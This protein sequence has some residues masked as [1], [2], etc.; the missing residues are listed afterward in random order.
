[1][2]GCMRA[3][4]QS[5]NDDGGDNEDIKQAQRVPPSAFRSRTGGLDGHIAPSH[6]AMVVYHS[7]YVNYIGLYALL[8]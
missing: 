5:E 2:R 6:P 3:R 7:L 8:N 1:M 4:S